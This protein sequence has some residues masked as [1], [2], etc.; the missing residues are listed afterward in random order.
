MNI[1]GENTW[2]VFTVFRFLV[3]RRTQLR[4]AIEELLSRDW[5]LASC[6]LVLSEYHGGLRSKESIK[7]RRWEN[8]RIS[9]ILNNTQ[10]TLQ[11]SIN[12]FAL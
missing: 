5:E 12:G 8:C 9:L 10:G 11:L 2:N 4:T 7:I 1:L 3:G 6:Y